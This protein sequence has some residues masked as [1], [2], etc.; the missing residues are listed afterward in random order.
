MLTEI[1]RTYPEHEVN[2]RLLAI[3]ADEEDNFERKM[4]ILESIERS[5]SRRLQRKLLPLLWSNSFNWRVHEQIVT[6][7][8]RYADRSILQ[9]LKSK[10]ADLNMELEKRASAAR[11]LCSCADSATLD[12]LLQIAEREEKRNT[13]WKSVSKAGHSGKSRSV[14]SHTLCATSASAFSPFSAGG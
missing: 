13:L 2:D 4:I 5:G 10:V 8:G 11:L 7:L 3:V 9:T 6:I 12:W 1:G 14:R